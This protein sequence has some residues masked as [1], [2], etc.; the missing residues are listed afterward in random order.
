MKRNIALGCAFLVLALLA[1]PRTTA[2]TIFTATLLGSNEVPPTGS[3]ASGFITVTLSGNLLSVHETFTGLVGGA[4]SA[5]HIH[6]CGVPGVNEP[7]AVPFT[8]FPGATSG[9]Y[10]ASFDLT[11]TATYTSAFVTASGG[12][13]ADAESALIP[14]LFAGQTYANIH[15]SDFPG[16]EIR[17]QLIQQ[18]PEPGTLMLLGMG[19]AGIVAWRK[20]RTA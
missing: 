11:L 17:G 7:V 5:A 4:A 16:G 12:T 14:A 20:R 2:D 13:A 1:A 18:T 10:D 9:T 3:P 15:D 6:C 8:G 19:F